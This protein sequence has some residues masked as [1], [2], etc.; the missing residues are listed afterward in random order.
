MV[1]RKSPSGL[2][3]VFVI[4]GNKREVWCR[5]ISKEH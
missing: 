4:S 5:K 2:E 1:S 3:R